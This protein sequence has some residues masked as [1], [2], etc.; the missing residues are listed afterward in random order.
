MRKHFLFAG[1]LLAAAL[2]FAVPSKADTVNFEVN[3]PGIFA[4]F[5]LPQGLTPDLTQGSTV[6]VFNIDGTLFGGGHSGPQT[7]G[8]IDLTNS[9]TGF[10]RFGGSGLAGCVA[11]P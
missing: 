3:G 2:V 8:T 10:W 5:S 9:A 1:I 7:F 11:C 4:T 6:L